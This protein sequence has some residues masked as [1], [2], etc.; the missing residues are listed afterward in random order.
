MSATDI[1]ATYAQLETP[2]QQPAPQQ[3]GR[4]QSL[5]I[6]GL[7]LRVA[8]RP[9][10]SNP[11]WCDCIAGVQPPART[12]AIQ[13]ELWNM[14]AIVAALLVG[15]CATGLFTA[16]KMSRSATS[17]RERLMGHAT[18]MLFC[19]STFNFLGSSLT[20]VAFRG[21]ASSTERPLADIIV[22]LGFAFH[23]PN[24][25]FR[26]G[27]LS[28]IVALTSFFITA[29]IDVVPT[30]GCLAVCVLVVIVPLFIAM[31][32]ALSTF[33]EDATKEEKAPLV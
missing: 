7:G 24:V 21:F 23:L 33:R 3:L 32:R 4:K 6:L 19:F 10:I 11:R 2:Q 5:R 15:M 14:R 26:V 18:T 1:D 22:V 30:L 28:A 13:L 12:K 9:D 25:F 31:Y 27:G 17:E 20:S 16:A 29:D 8:S